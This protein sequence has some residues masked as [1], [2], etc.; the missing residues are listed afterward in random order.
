MRVVGKFSQ[1]PVP[2][3]PA[4]F[5]KCGEISTRSALRP[6]ATTSEPKGKAASPTPPLDFAGNQR[7]NTAPARK[8]RDFHSKW[9]GSI[10]RGCQAEFQVKRL[11]LLPEIAHVT[12][13]QC[14]HTNR[15]GVKVHGDLAMEARTSFSAHL[16]TAMKEWVIA[17]LD[18]GLTV[19]QV[20][21]HHREKLFSTMSKLEGDG[22]S[23]LTLDMFLSHQDVRNLSSK[24]AAETYRLHQNDALS[25]R[26]W[27]ETNRDS[28]FYYKE[29]G[30]LG[31]G[32]LQAQNI[33]FVVGIQT[34]WQKETMLKF[35]HNSGVAIDAT[36]GTSAK[37]VGTSE[38]MSCV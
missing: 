1:L 30:K 28:V 14:E 12:F 37:K 6:W 2:V 10:K 8:R 23:I 26:M 29:T 31:P 20:L 15:V 4:G 5:V 35:G 21:A 9:G 11:F 33:P 36:F 7:S 13:R 3:Q 19:Q 16:S 24:K 18:L 27:V 32:A 17:Q 38:P 25:V 34:P 22:A